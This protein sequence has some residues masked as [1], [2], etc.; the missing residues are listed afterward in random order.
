MDDNRQSQVCYTERIVKLLC[1]HKAVRID[2]E[3]SFVTGESVYD[4]WLLIG[5]VY[6]LRFMTSQL[7][8]D[9]RQE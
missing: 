7:H 4:N 9:Q 2:H 3:S 5:M 6:G 1:L 8:C